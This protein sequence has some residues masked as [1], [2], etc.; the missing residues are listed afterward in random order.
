MSLSAEPVSIRR[1]TLA[2]VGSVIELAGSLREA[3][4]WPP[5][6]YATALDRDAVPHRIT[7]VAETRQTLVGFIIAVLVTPEAELELVA[8]DPAFQRRGIGRQLMQRLCDELETSDITEVTLEV[9]ASNESAK[10][11][12]TSLG[13]SVS[14]L[15]ARYYADPIEDAIQMKILL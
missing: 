3:P 5:S 6:A 11:L 10:A 8:V 4:D 2:D 9:R 12:Y 13:F 14:G 15:R 7:L 1:M